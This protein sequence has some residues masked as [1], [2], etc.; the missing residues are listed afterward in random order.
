MADC[1]EPVARDKAELSIHIFQLSDDGPANET[2][3]G[4]DGGDEEVT[5]CS[6]WAMPMPS[7]SGHVGLQYLGTTLHF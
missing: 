3:G 1:E 5:T 6:Q 2:V 4:E 7:I